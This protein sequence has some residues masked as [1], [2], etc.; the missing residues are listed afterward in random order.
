[1]KEAMASANWAALLKLA[2]LK[3]FRLKMPNHI[4]TWLSQL[5]DVGV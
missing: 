2:P 4:S 5:A 1:M 3:T